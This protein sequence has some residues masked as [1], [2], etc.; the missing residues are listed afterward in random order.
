MITFELEGGRQACNSFVDAIRDSVAYVPTLGDVNSILLH[1]STVFGKEQD[2]GEGMV[3]LSV[4]CEPWEDL[5]TVF[6]NAL[7]KI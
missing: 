5:R 1:I 2:P 3:R 4:G 7:M 6:T